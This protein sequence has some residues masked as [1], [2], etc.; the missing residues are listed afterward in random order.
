MTSASICL[1]H[2][3]CSAVTL[4]F[5]VLHVTLYAF[6]FLVAAAAALAGADRK[7]EGSTRDEG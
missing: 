5:C 3:F 4:T 2:V 7:W 1:W 6:L